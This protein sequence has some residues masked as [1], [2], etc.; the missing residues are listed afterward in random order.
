MNV[1]L[2]GATG[3]I[4]RHVLEGLL[5]A[6]QVTQVI[7]PTRRTLSVP[8]VRTGNK[9]RNVLIDFDRLDEY[10]E[11]FDVTTIIC[12]LGTTIKQAGSKQNFRKVDY[13]YCRDA[14]ELGR[15]QR[16]RAF[17][18]V[19]AIGS[20]ISSPFFYSR[21]KGELEQHLLDLEYNQLSIYR[22]S[23]LLG[24]RDEFRLGEKIY[25]KLT[26]LVDPFMRGPL[27]HYH[28]IQGKTVAQ[29]MVNECLQL[30]EVIPAGPKVNI[31]PYDKIV[32]LAQGR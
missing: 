28:A 30:G 20:S 9:L 10:P 24:E 6:S 1:L 17:L 29:A 26:P 14:A 7:A 11:L 12:C 31:Y 23:M 32:K 16:A 3:L 4:G 13:Q 22:P 15:A 8:E 5:A 21:V 25:S 2:L 18:L 27:R 19:S